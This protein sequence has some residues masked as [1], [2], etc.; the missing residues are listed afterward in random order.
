MF[1]IRTLSFQQIPSVQLV[2]IILKKVKMRILVLFC[3]ISATLAAAAVVHEQNANLKEYEHHA[4]FAQNTTEFGVNYMYGES[5]RCSVN[6]KCGGSV[7]LR[8]TGAAQ[9]KLY[10]SRSSVVF[11]R[12]PYQ[13]LR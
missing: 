10:F 1:S 11:H 5:H 6:N 12:F 8:W 2:D 4:V 3:L 7:T 9:S 13:R